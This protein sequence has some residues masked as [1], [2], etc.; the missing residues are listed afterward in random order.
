MAIIGL[1]KNTGKTFALN[2]LLAEGRRLGITTAI[3][4]VG[5]D[6]EERDSLFAHNKPQILV[7]PG[8]IVATARGLL[9]ASRLDYEVLSSTGIMTQLGEVVLVR[10]QGCGSVVLAGPSTRDEL[11]CLQE[12]LLQFDYDLLLVDGAV[13]RRSLAAPTVTDTAIFAVGAEAAWERS[14][15]LEKLRLQWQLLTLPGLDRP[16]LASHLQSVSSDTKMVVLASYEVWHSVLQNEVAVAGKVL[17]KYIEQGADSVFIRGALT[18]EV[19][20]P[21]L[22]AAARATPFTLLVPDS[23]YVF[24]SGRGFQRLASSRVVLKVLNPIDISAVTVNPFN[25]RYGYAEPVKLLEDVGRAV[26]PVPCYDLFLGTRY[27]PRGYGDAIS[28]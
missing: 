12:G 2:Q 6:G 3:T 11:V 14:E 21:V 1:G 13:D 18:D 27:R 28:R 19:L 9:A 17:A 7:T 4:S 23:T 16:D 10:A 25:S 5:L 15:L 20:S 24:L 8:Q 26:D 22:A